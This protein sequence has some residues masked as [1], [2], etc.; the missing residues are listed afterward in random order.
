MSLR[1]NLKYIGQGAES[2]LV[3]EQFQPELMFRTRGDVMPRAP[4]IHERIHVSPSPNGTSTL[5]TFSSSSAVPSD[6]V[7]KINRSNCGDIVH[8]HMWLNFQINVNDNATAGETYAST[9]PAVVD[10]VA[11]AIDTIEFWYNNRRFGSRTGREIV[12]W[13]ETLP[14]AEQQAAKIAAEAGFGDDVAGYNA[15]QKLFCSNVH[16]VKVRVPHPFMNDPIP[17]YALPSDIEV[18]VRWKPYGDWLQQRYARTGTALDTSYTFGTS[19]VLYI[20]QMYL[21]FDTKHLL[22]PHRQALYSMVY[23]RG[24]SFKNYYI[25]RYTETQ[26]KG[27][28][29]TAYTSEYSIPLTTF[30]APA[31]VLNVI[32]IHQKNLGAVT[33]A[34]TCTE[35]VRPNNFLPITYAKIVDGSKDVTET[36]YWEP[37]YY[38]TDVMRTPYLCEQYAGG[39][40][41]YPDCVPGRKLARIPLCEPSNVLDSRVRAHGSRILSKYNQP[42]LQVRLNNWAHDYISA[43]A[44]TAG[45]TAATQHEGWDSDKWLNFE[46]ASNSTPIVA[47]AD[48]M[49][50]ITFIVWA[51]CHNF[52]VI[53]RGDLK[54]QFDVA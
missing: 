48:A 15:R 33:G 32:A 45:T 25:Q 3:N 9:A 6:V 30:T 36:R 50:L 52:I 53:N 17:V 44:I 20:R 2:G 8:G 27:T 24:M 10:N 16:Y 34:N 28:S 37:K 35:S 43:N 21:A 54:T 38:P 46:G 1:S 22:E 40:A 19:Q 13:M 39:V 11:H 18:R 7:F 42:T 5:S 23:S 26:N 4:T 12:E 14:R 49:K 41:M 47:G 31:Y 29:N 51:E